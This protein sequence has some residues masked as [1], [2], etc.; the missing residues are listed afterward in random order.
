[1]RQ[2]FIFR[3]TPNR[4]TKGTLLVERF[5]IV[6]VRYGEILFRKGYFH[7]NSA[8]IRQNSMKQFLQYTFVLFLGMVGFGCTSSS[9]EKTSAGWLPKSEPAK[10]EATEKHFRG[11][12]VAMMEIGYRYQEL[13]W[14]GK[15]GNWLYAAYQLDKIELSLRLAI[16]RRPL[17]K[18]SA[19]VFLD[20]P[21]KTMRDGI[22]QANPEMFTTQFKLFTAHCNACHKAENVPFFMVREPEIRTSVVKISP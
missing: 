10:T 3:S 8:E 9:T 20:E 1:V 6:G 17:R 5:A 4:E 21:V 19:Q 14:A 11:L 12:D 15:D 7:F 13:Y 16:E 18:E 22:S 2:G